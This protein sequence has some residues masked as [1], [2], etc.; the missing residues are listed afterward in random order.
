MSNRR[1]SIKYKGWIITHDPYGTMACYKLGFDT[2]LQ[3][4]YFGN[5]L[6]EVKRRIDEIE[7]I[8]NAE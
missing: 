7:M 1:W 3:W 8:S 6:E 5:S 2:P 4:C